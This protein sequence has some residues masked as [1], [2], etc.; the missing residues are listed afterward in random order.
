MN[1]FSYDFHIQLSKFCSPNCAP[2]LFPSAQW[3]T[4]FD[5]LC[6]FETKSGISALYADLPNFF[7]AEKCNQPLTAPH[8]PCTPSPVCCRWGSV[9][10][11]ED[12]RCSLSGGVVHEARVCQLG[13][14]EEICLLWGLHVASLCQAAVAVKCIYLGWG[15]RRRVGRKHLKLHSTPLP[16]KREERHM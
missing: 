3:R 1:N 6:P 7:P 15:R 13:V 11:A 4:G 12:G 9:P 2:R 5:I 16:S 14:R 10:G 8:S